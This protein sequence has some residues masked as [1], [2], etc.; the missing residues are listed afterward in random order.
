MNNLAAHYIVARLIFM[1]L[2]K[3]G[4]DTF[5]DYFDTSSQANVNQRYTH[6]TWGRIISK[7]GYFNAIS[8]FKVVEIC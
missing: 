4:L 8:L 1:L 6:F 7:F 3:S 5:L 2:L